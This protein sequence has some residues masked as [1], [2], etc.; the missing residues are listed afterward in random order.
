MRATNDFDAR[1]NNNRAINLTDINRMFLLN[2][3]TQQFINRFI[4]NENLNGLNNN[5]IRELAINN[6]IALYNDP[7]D[8][9]YYLFEDGVGDNFE[10][11][12]IEN[13]CLMFLSY[14]SF[15][16]IQ[17]VD[18]NFISAYNESLNFAFNVISS[19]FYLIEEYIKFYFNDFDRRL[20]IPH[21]IT[22]NGITREMTAVERQEFYVEVMQNTE[23]KYDFNFNPGDNEMLY[24]FLFLYFGIRIFISHKLRIFC[25]LSTKDENKIFQFLKSNNFD[26]TPDAANDG[27]FDIDQ[28]FQPENHEAPLPEP[29]MSLNKTIK[30]IGTYTRANR[31]VNN[32]STNPDNFLYDDE[33][34]VQDNRLHVAIL[35]DFFLSHSNFALSN[36]DKKKNYAFNIILENFVYDIHRFEKYGNK[37]DFF[38]D[39][40]NFKFSFS[41]I[42]YLFC[43]SLSNEIRIYD[44][45]L[46]FFRFI[47]E[48]IIKVYFN[49][50][51]SNGTNLF[52]SLIYYTYLTLGELP[53]TYLELSLSNVI[54]KLTKD[55]PEYKSKTIDTFKVSINT[56]DEVDL[57]FYNLDANKNLYVLN[58]K[59]DDVIDSI[60]PEF[61]ED[62]QISN[63]AERDDRF[64][65]N[66][67]VTF[68]INIPD[69]FR[70]IHKFVPGIK[71]D[72]FDI[73]DTTNNGINEYKLIRIVTKIKEIIENDQN[74][75]VVRFY[76][77]ARVLY[78][79]YQ[80]LKD[81]CK[82]LSIVFDMRYFNRIVNMVG[83]RKDTFFYKFIS[84]YGTPVNVDKLNYNIL[85]DTYPSFIRINSITE[86][87]NY[88]MMFKWA[89][90]NQIQFYLVLYY[91]E[92][93]NGDVTKCIIP[94]DRVSSH[95]LTA[96]F[97]DNGG[98]H[99]EIANTIQ[100]YNLT[101]ANSRLFY[102]FSMKSVEAIQLDLNTLRGDARPEIYGNYLP[103]KLLC[104]ND[105]L[106][107][108]AF[109]CQLYKQ[110]EK[111][112]Q[113]YNCFY[114]MI[115]INNCYG[116]NKN[117]FTPK[118]LAEIYYKYGKGNITLDKIKQFHN[119]YKVNIEIKKIVYSYGGIDISYKDIYKLNNKEYKRFLSFGHIRYEKFNHFF[120]IVPTKIT[121]FC[122]KNLNLTK[123]EYYNV[124]SSSGIKIENKEIVKINRIERTFQN[125]FFADT[126]E[127]FKALLKQ[128][129]IDFVSAYEM[130]QD[131]CNTEEVNPNINMI[132]KYPEVQTKVVTNDEILNTKNKTINLIDSRKK[133]KDVIA[134]A[135]SETYVDN[136]ND[137]QPFCL[138]LVYNTLEGE[139]VK[140]SFYGEYCQLNF[141]KYLYE[142]NIREVYFHNLKFDA[143][144][145]KRFQIVD[146][147]YH[148]SR[149]YRL[150]ILF[151]DDK[152]KKKKKFYFKDSLALIP[153][154]LKNFNKMFNLGEIEKELYPYNKINETVILE[155]ELLID[156]CKDEFS[157]EDF[158]KFKEMIYNN[159]FNINENKIDVEKL[160]IFYCLRDC[161]VLYYGLKKFEEMTMELF[162]NTNGLRFLTISS[163]SF[164][165]MTENC[166]SGLNKYCGDIKKFI[167]KAIRGGRCMVQNNQK[168]KVNDEIV[169]FDACSLYPSAMSR[170]YLPTGKVYASNDKEEIKLIYK[171]LMDEDQVIISD[172]KF[173][174]AMIIKCKIIKVGKNRT[175]PLLSIMEDG[176]S[177][178]T[179]SME[180]KEVYLTHIEL[181]DFIKY[182]EGEV[183]FLECIYWVGKKDVRMA[184]KIKYFYNLRAKY[185]SEGNQLQ[186]VLKLFMNSS[187][188][189]TIQKDTE[190]ED[191]M[192]NKNTTDIFLKNN[193][194][195]IKEVIE[196]NNE[197]YWIKLDGSS[198][199]NYIPVQI[200]CL[201]LGMSKRIMNEVICT[202]EDNNIDVYYQD[203]DSIHIKKRDVESLARAFE[204]SFGRELI[205][206]EMGQFH[207]DFPLIN[208]KETWSKKSIFLGKKCYI[209]CLTNIDGE[210][211][212][213]I[214]MKGVPEKVIRN[215]A[216]DMNIQ[217]YELYDKMYD[218]EE[219]SFDLLN[220]NMP[221]FEYQKNFGIKLREEFKRILKFK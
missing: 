164:Y 121:K 22:E 69:R 160:T 149:L 84:V 213:F 139:I 48:F 131:L 36:H 74:V 26:I 177:N 58:Y 136:N 30:R 157:K 115:H 120:A 179:N 154:K 220:S 75:T 187:Y 37:G 153:T 15:K 4:E 81:N 117:L 62:I 218:G 134:V 66:L 1:F 65:D 61:T 169:D 209:D 171:C 6:F 173:V 99:D 112:D 210:E 174:S 144:L 14:L 102:A 221:S 202:A 178:Y 45:L 57:P 93:N 29:F 132:K 126:Y 199:C 200:G 143:W 205:G 217:L 13:Y 192:F 181:Q 152:K 71:C 2:N 125:E 118:E 80:F 100:Y 175:F 124:R 27:D 32:E 204:A 38:I 146:I 135:D 16:I 104:Y 215:T 8:F 145:F 207:V 185:K 170:L 147:T 21:L 46:D 193:Y 127:L 137:L 184:E 107:D 49:I 53:N 183:E 155:N 17:T 219:I 68:D 103:L 91:K 77:L 189:K 159:D 23:Y 163:L 113:K 108:F 123:R 44:Y 110:G 51:L 59:E 78:C 50:D 70:F 133:V 172:K 20:P 150:C 201:I 89:F 195:R 109:Y 188:G 95:F 85:K 156:D 106:N 211:E 116:K 19:K 158:I 24:N 216:K 11:E 168:I 180:G 54:N 165:V 161:E 25:N 97:A 105:E 90:K 194:G 40:N 197:T 41:L 67:G 186:E 82:C 28:F 182:Q 33:N 140:K 119:E 64:F 52:T 88:V 151:T 96:A 87:E 208:N 60:F 79:I 191:R 31:L 198:S 83:I 162:N 34:E 94:I 214:R 3:A 130:E 7:F 76:K 141:L 114:W 92:N 138:C 166:F 18:F 63:H 206:V 55:I 148:S 129:L 190:N 10:K 39:D 35:K 5:E 86:V 98:D 196:I 43:V 73:L 42:F 12:N 176:I 101:R 56:F 9:I 111:A 72:P 212:D 203:T 167:R 128:D 142:E 47:D 122:C